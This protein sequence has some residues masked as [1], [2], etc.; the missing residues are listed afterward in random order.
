MVGRGERTTLEPRSPRPENH[1]WACC[2]RNLLPTLRIVASIAVL[3]L[4]TLS[5]CTSDEPDQP[6]GASSDSSGERVPSVERVTEPEGDWFESSCALDENLLRRVRAGI[7]PDRSPDITAV[8]REPNY[9][10][11]F[12]VFT[13]S[14]P[15]DYVQR[16]PL[17]FYGPGFIKSRGLLKLDRLVTLAD[18]APTLAE[19]VGTELP[20]TRPGRP[21]AEALV[22]DS[23]R[24]QPKVIVQIVWD[25]GGTNVLEQWP[26]AWPNLERIMAEGTSIQDVEVGSS[27]SVTP[28]VHATIGTGSFPKQHEIVDIP[29]RDGDEVVG[30]YA[31][32]SPSIL[33]QTTVAD[34]YDQQVG[35][36]AHIGLFSYRPWHW[37]LAG[38]GAQIEGGDKDIVF[39]NNPNGE[40][41]TNPEY[42]AM[43]DYATSVPGLEDY[44]EQVDREDGKA[45][46]LWMGNDILE[47]TPADLRDS[48]AWAL[49]Q[50]DIATTIMEREGFGDDDITDLFFMNYKQI[51]EVGHRFN[52]LEPEVREIVRY[53]DSELERLMSWLDLNVGKR[54]WVIMVTA[55]HGQGPDPLRSGAW[56]IA[57]DP[58]LSDLGRALDVDPNRLIQG[59][60]PGAYWVDENVLREE[61]VT[62]ENIAAFMN[63]YRLEDNVLE[64]EDVPELYRHRLREPLFS[65]AFPT[66]AMGRI[67]SCAKRRG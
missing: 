57:K 49:Y 1:K 18:I 38:H 30:S 50:T 6:P 51:D 59:Q 36:M 44:T 56:P 5:A 62:L 37:G 63:D 47:T 46:G 31:N 7:N 40:Y 41:Q 4:L 13:H 45:D 33:A 34:V 20:G 3:G 55:D 29:V 32:R 28:A 58:L 15:W 48:P 2:G 8:P 27:P 22:D 10:G 66:S 54:E 14:G 53:S 12:S 52:M 16:V 64:G 19:L 26:K 24:G 23:R 35:N 17:A 9:F 21:I 60:R 61:G 11:G 39:V 65:A 43:P 42:Y 67:W 25:G